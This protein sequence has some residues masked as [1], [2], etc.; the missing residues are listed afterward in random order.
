MSGKHK[1][2]DK[3]RS[4]SRSR[5]KNVEKKEKDRERSHKRYVAKDLQS[6][7]NFLTYKAIFFA[8][9]GAKARTESAVEVKVTVKGIFFNIKLLPILNVS[10]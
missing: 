5:S 3:E 7:S 6:R 4:R 1:D 9:T 2:K 10:S 8:G